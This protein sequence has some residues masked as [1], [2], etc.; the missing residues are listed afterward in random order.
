MRQTTSEWE[1]EFLFALW[2]NV[3]MKLLESEARNKGY[4][5]YVIR[6]ET[7]A[8]VRNFQEK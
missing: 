8:L 2:D 7:D 3:V 4:V 6:S 1:S 5:V